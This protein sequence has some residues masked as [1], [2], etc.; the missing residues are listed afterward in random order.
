MH[1][2]DQIICTNCPTLLKILNACPTFELFKNSSLFSINFQLDYKILEEI[3]YICL[4]VSPYFLS[5]IFLVSLVLY[6]T[7]RSLGVLSLSF[8]QNFIV[9]ILKNS[10]RDPRPNFKCNQQFGNPSNHSVFF[11][12]LI[13]WNIMEYILLD[14]KFRFRNALFQLFI[15]ALFP[16]VLYSRYKLN[17]HNAEQLF[18]GCVVGIFTAAL[19]F[20]AFDS[21]ILKGEGFFSQL[22]SQ[23]GIQNNMSKYVIPPQM[24]ANSYVKYMELMKKQEELAKMKSELRGFRDNIKNLELLKNNEGNFNDEI[25]NLNTLLNDNTPNTEYNENMT[26][27]GQYENQND[28][29]G[30]Y[31][32][33]EEE[34]IQVE[35]VRN[36]KLKTD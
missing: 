1:S 8:I 14:K 20:M 22:L 28:E 26:N 17:Y 16:L 36:G 33:I 30:E 5:F 24:N 10:L 23:L 11:S 21:F 6:R 19:W 15:F 29:D 4:S 25:K 34:D 2:N 9:Q 18:N 32:E 3:V 35:N 27:P 31:E 13:M 7:T 12:A